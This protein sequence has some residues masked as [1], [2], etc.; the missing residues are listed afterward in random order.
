MMEQAYADHEEARLNLKLYD[1]QI[2]TTEAAIQVL[3]AQYAG[4]NQ[5]FDELLQ[6][7]AL[8]LEYQLRKLQAVV[9]SY[10]ARA[11][12]ERYILR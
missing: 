7:E 6:L 5:G 3:E 4:Q 2:E 9:K 12:I 10:I 1:R 8:L 11:S